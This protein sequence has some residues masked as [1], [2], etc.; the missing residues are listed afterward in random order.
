VAIILNY[1]KGMKLMVID[2]LAIVL[3]LF[4]I[5]TGIF[6]VK[7]FYSAIKKKMEEK[8]TTSLIVLASFELLSVLTST[9][10]ILTA[11]IIFLF[12]LFLVLVFTI[13]L[14]RSLFS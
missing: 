4:M 11:I 13:D 6:L 9:G 10:S 5:L 3:G 14:I 7:L 12:G 2:V 1:N 8:D